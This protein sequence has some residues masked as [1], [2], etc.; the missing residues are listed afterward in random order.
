MNTYF[1]TEML[2]GRLLNASIL[3]YKLVNTGVFLSQIC[4]TAFSEYNIV[5][6]I[7]ITMFIECS[8]FTVQFSEYRC[9]TV[10]ISEY[11]WFT[12]Y[13]YF[14]ELQYRSERVVFLYK[15]VN[16]VFIKCSYFTLQIIECR[17][18]LQICSTVFGDFRGFT[19]LQYTVYWILCF[20][21]MQ[22]G[23]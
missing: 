17:C 14:T 23:A 19:H 3:L 12:G 5:L 21:N 6:L 15:F 16:T 8:C 4:I 2:C 13:S 20:S 10:Q 7:C 18:F 1:F 9:F 11:N 22:H